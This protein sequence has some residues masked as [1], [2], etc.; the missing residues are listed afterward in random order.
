MASKA[1]LLAV[2]VVAA[3]APA[4]A[5]DY[6]V[7]DDAGW[8]LNVNYTAWAQGKVFYVGDTIGTYTKWLESAHVIFC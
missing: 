2:M 8:N 6:V 1:F 4:L 7:G 5:V 3:A